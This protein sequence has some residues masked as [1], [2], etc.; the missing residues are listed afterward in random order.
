MTVAVGLRRCAHK[1]LEEFTEETG[2]GKVQCIGHFY[3]RR[4][5]VLEQHLG[6]RYH[7]VVNPILGRGT[8]CLPHRR[9]QVALGDAQPIGI[10]SEIA[11]LRA[12]VVN[13]SYEAVENA[14]CCRLLRLSSRSGSKN[15]PHNPAI[16]DTIP[17]NAKLF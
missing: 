1:A 12:I 11:V 2:I 8:T 5:A 4:I 7:G 15:E 3:Y 13:E 16:A 6:R 9:A 14:I 10:E 17:L